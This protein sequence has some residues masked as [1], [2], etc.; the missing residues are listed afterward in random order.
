MEMDIRSTVDI[1]LVFY[2]VLKYLCKCSD[3][4]LCV[5]VFI[6]FLFCFSLLQCWGQTKGLVYSTIEPPGLSCFLFKDS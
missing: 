3:I 5:C 6:M 4:C 1:L 2:N